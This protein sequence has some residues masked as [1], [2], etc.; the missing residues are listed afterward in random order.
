MIH[1]QLT[2]RPLSVPVRI[3]ILLYHNIYCISEVIN[4]PSISIYVNDKLYK[5]LFDK[6]PSPAVAGKNII[7]SAFNKQKKETENATQ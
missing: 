5:Y 2:F 7:E 4:I 3:S 6:G 1:G